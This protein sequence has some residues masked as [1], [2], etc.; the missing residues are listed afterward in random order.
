MNF[1]VLWL[2]MKVFSA[3]F[4][5]VVCPLVQQKQAIRENFLS[6]NRVFHQF[7]KVFSLKSF[8]LYDSR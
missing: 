1:V 2:F 7:V 6:K 3:K 5:S 8:P 4:G